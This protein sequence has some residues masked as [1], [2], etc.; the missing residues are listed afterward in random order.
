MDGI[1]HSWP[2]SWSPDG[3]VL[4]FVTNDGAHRAS[5]ELTGLDIWWASLDDLTHPHLFLKT[6]FD[7]GP[8]VFSPDGRWLA[9]ASNESGRTEIYVQPFPGP[10]E[11]V[12]I[13]TDGGNEVTWPRLGH[14]LFYRSANVMMAVDVSAGRR[15][16]AGQPRR[17]FEGDFAKSTAFW[18]NYDVSADG[19]RFLMIRT[20]DDRTPPTPIN[21]IVNW[22]EELKQRVPT[23]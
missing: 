18:P 10:G 16:S 9:Y 17:L 8:P 22:Q 7:E 23:R 5:S 14:Q 2:A 19:Q 6:K 13:S 15:F 3:R 11:R 12:Q 4:A 20:I 21:V 1:Q